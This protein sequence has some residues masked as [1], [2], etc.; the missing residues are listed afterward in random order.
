M[1]IQ[2]EPINVPEVGK[3]LAD[4]GCKD[5]SDRVVVMPAFDPSTWGQR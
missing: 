4:Q 3:E 5:C 1:D 2:A